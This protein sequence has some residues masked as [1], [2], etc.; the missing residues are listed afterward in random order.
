MTGNIVN[1]YNTNDYAL[2]SGTILWGVKQTNWEEDQRSTKPDSFVAGGLEYAYYPS[3]FTSIEYFPYTG[4]SS[5]ITDLQEIKALVARS[6]SHAI[7]S[8]GGVQGVMNA[9][10]A[11]DLKASFQFGNTRPDHSAEFARNIQV[12]LPYYQQMIRSFRIY[13]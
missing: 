2:I 4:H 13:Q 1:F 5:T 3:N 10:G 9:S 7:G 6:R 12:V 8:S 11:V